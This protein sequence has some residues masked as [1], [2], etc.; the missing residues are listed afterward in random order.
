MQL[1]YLGVPQEP[2]AD[3]DPRAAI[4]RTPSHHEQVSAVKQLLQVFPDSSIGHLWGIQPEPPEAQHFVEVETTSNPL[5]DAL[6]HLILV[7]G[8]LS[9]V[10]C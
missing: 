6:T 10:D 1:F 4:D 2:S 5:E 9:T 3:F 8:K 7:P